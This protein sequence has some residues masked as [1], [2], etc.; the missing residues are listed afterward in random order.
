MKRGDIH[1]I[2]KGTTGGGERCAQVLKRKPHLRVE[3]GLRRAVAAAA[4]LA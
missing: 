1:Q 2:V 3:I 4:H